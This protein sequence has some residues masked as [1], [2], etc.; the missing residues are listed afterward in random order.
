MSSAAAPPTKV[1]KR[2][3]GRHGFSP[4]KLAKLMPGLNLEG[5]MATEIM[6]EDSELGQD[7]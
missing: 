7:I 1:K 3:E 4:E 6:Q 5:L 2:E